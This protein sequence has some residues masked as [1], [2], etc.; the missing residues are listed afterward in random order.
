[1]LRNTTGKPLGL[2]ANVY[3]KDKNN[4]N[5]DSTANRHEWPLINMIR[6]LKQVWFSGNGVLFD[7][8][9]TKSR[10]TVFAN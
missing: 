7:S 2:C 4:K 6:F 8:A 10:G 5:K 1:M 3:G 9:N